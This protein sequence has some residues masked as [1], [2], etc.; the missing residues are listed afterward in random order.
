MNILLIGS[1]GREHAIACRIAESERCSALY[2]APGNAGTAR[3]NKCCNVDVDPLDFEA[4]RAVVHKHDIDMLVVGPE[5]PLVAG[6]TDFFA[7]NSDLRNVMVV[8]P[9]KAGAQLEG[10]KDFAK[11]FMQRHGI[12]TAAYRSFAASE[13][14]EG[15]AFLGTLQA[16]YVLKADGLAAGKGVLILDSLDEA[17]HELR[18]MLEG[19]FGQASAKVVVEQYLDGVELSVFVLTDGKHYKIL[20]TAKDYKRIGEGDTG[21]NTG[22]MGSVSPVHFADKRFMQKVEERIVAPTVRG[23]SRDGIPYKGFI[24]VG[25]MAV[26]D[27]ATGELDPYVIEYNVRMGDPETECV[28][29]RIKSDVVDLFERVWRGNLQQTELTVDPR[30]AACVMM[31]SGGYPGHY[32]KGKPIQG[33]EQVTDCQVFH[34]G[35][36]L[37]DDGTLVTSGGR[38]LCVTALAN[39]MPMAML[40]S[41]Q[42]LAKISWEDCYFRRDIGQD[43]LKM[44]V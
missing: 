7:A 12:P 18:E 44:L 31:V 32:A 33:V 41:Y 9:G 28:F 26:A 39:S 17:R 35:T 42:E 34:A 22:G 23:L 5:A 30:A 29:P 2:V 37:A 38:V 15:E 11:Q 6:V 14:A 13:A 4:L 3:V 10:S 36:R 25:L 43:L 16:P 27:R 1:G 8:G 40:K 21:L 20:P 19:K 24:F